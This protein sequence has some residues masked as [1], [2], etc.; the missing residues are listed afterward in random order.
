MRFKQWAKNL[1]VFAAPI[2]TGTT[3]LKVL[4]GVGVA[5]LAMCFASS[6]AYALNDVL[7][8]ERD[9]MH[10]KKK[11]RPI[12]A[13]EVLESTGVALS[14][15]LVVIALGLA[16]AINRATLWLVLTY[17]GLQVLYNFGLKRVPIAD[18]FLIALGFVLRAVVGA[19]ALGVGIS[20]WLLFVT[21]A[22]AVMLGFSKRRDEFLRIG[23]NLGAS[24]ESLAGYSKPILD[25]LVGLFAGAAMLSYGIYSIESPT[26][27]AHPGLMTT[28]LFV[29][30]GI[31]RYLYLVFHDGKGEEPEAIL[32]GDVHILASVLLFLGFA[33]LAIMD[34]L[35]TRFLTQ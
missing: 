7:D 24:R 6:A 9:R 3:N 20:G 18:V 11:N 8:A 28:T 35:P 21:G 19:V 12:A 34:K 33:I 16:L 26:A 17:L 32:F 5:F 31:C 22:L 10:P 30:Y 4:S 14:I 13:G 2:F 27:M 1:L 29:W 25:L 15:V 23:E